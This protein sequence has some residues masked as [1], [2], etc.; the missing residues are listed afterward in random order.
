M[1]GKRIADTVPSVSE[2]LAD[3]PSIAQGMQ[4]IS[5]RD[6]LEVLVATDGEMEEVVRSRAELSH[7]ENRFLLYKKKT[8]I[9]ER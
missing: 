3:G 9:F 5:H 2:D 6:A 7:T 8:A 1:Q 4:R